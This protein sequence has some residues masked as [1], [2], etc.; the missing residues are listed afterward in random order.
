M[1]YARITFAELEE[2]RR[3][4]KASGYKS[5]KQAARALNISLQQAVLY[6]P[7]EYAEMIE[8]QFTELHGAVWNPLIKSNRKSNDGLP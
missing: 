3:S 8:E 7:W 5:L 6:R 1:T 4:A 2:A